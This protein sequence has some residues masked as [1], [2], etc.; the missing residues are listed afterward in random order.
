[1]QLLYSISVIGVPKSFSALLPYV[2]QAAQA[3]VDSRYVYDFERKIFAFGEHALQAHLRGKALGAQQGVL[4]EDAD[5]LYRPSCAETSECVRISIARYDVQSA[6][7]V[8]HANA[9][10][11]Y[12]RVGCYWGCSGVQLNMASFQ[13]W[14]R[15]GMISL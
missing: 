4:A 2:M 3:M 7:F 15:T 14:R 11:A 13:C 10:I 12:L 6:C 9:L 5:D 8:Q 1:V